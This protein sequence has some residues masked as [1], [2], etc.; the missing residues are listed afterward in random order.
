MK[1]F[2]LLMLLFSSF[3]FLYAQEKVLKGIVTDETDQPVPGASI[4]IKGTSTGTVT[5]LNGEYSLK[6]P[7][8]ATMISVSYIGYTTQEIRLTGKPVLNVKIVPSA[9][10]LKDVVV[11]GYGS[12]KKATMTG[13]VVSVNARDLLKTPVANMATALIGRT[14]GL[15]TYQSSGQPGADGITLRIRGVETINGSNPLVLVDGVERDFTQLD[16]N[17]VESFSILKDAASTAVFGVRGANGVIIVTTKKGVEGAAKVS[18]TSNFSIQQP[19]RLPKMIGAED[20]CRM[21]NEAQLN[22]VPTATP[23]FTDEDISKYSSKS[24]PLEYPNNDWFQLML[25]PNALQQQHNV[26]ISGG[27]K[28]TKYYTSVGYFTQDGLMK[29]YSSVLNRSLNNNYKYDRFNLRS[30]IDVDVTPT[31]KVGVMISGIISKTNDPGFN[32]STLLAST[33]LSYPLIY[34]DKIIGSTINFAGSPLMSSIGQSLTEKNGNTIALTLNLNQNLDMITKGLSFRAMGSYDSYYS[35]NITSNQGYILY[36][37][38]YL[39]DENGNNVR[40]LSP[41]G[42]NSLVTDPSEDWARNR[43]VHGEAALEYKKSFGNNNLSGL[44]LTTLDKKWYTASTYSYIPNT[45]SGIVGRFTYDYSSK[46]LLELNV[47]YNGSE[48]F[49]ANKRFAWFPAISAGWNA[50]EEKF[51]KNLISEN[52]LDKLKFRLSHGVVGNDQS[53]SRFLYNNNEYSAPIS[54]ASLYS[55][56]YFGDATQVLQ[57]RYVEGK[58][59]NQNVTWE[60]ATKDNIGVELSMFKNKLT[61]N[62]DFFMSDRKNILMPANSIPLHVVIYGPT[63]YFNIGRVKNH[64]YEFE[65]KWRQDIGKFSYFVGGNYSFARNKWIEMDEV[66]DI[67]NPNL[68][69][70]GRRIGENFGL[71]ADGFY[72]NTDEVSRGPII[73]NPGVGNARYVDVNGDGVINVKDMVPMGNPQFPEINY[74]VNFGTSYKGFELSILF[75]GA[76]NTSKM[77]GGKFQQP[78]AANGGVMD[79]VVAERWAPDNMANAVRPRLT[80]NYVNANDYLPSTMWLRD[81][82]YLKLRNVEFSYRF[83]SKFIKKA[84]GIAGLRIYANGQ[85][86]FTWDKL[87]IIDPEG[88]TS[89]SWTYPQLKVYNVGVKLDF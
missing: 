17:E 34:E 86:L 78:F 1:K 32:W 68:W 41:S 76:A 6:L 70:T 60:T 83:D 31:T 73:G 22:D 57:S 67:N 64:G 69:T 43:K 33:P 61:F 59:G 75:Q 71:I 26:T 49:P 66:K 63:D 62:A 10:G 27:T 46:Y 11:V 29:D 52:V 77:L 36:Y 50:A 74:G 80:L 51:V 39:P 85:N 20:F 44:L 25:K 87:K 45:Y 24:N 37:I 58:Q 19:T 28:S 40:Q 3:S 56:T 55:Y 23:R 2:L 72:N 65:G 30:N 8:T 13:S 7:A 47:G 53:G 38:N 89:D 12:Q 88:S 35:H 14:P 84:I 82:S 79:F 4:F 15:T 81:G 42:E 18:V 16:P 9:I 5:G 21:Y 54:P 48:N